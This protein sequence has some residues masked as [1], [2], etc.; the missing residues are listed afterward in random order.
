[1]IQ[2]LKTIFALAGWG[3]LE[4]FSEEDEILLLSVL[5]DSSYD[6]LDEGESSACSVE[7]KIFPKSTLGFRELGKK[8][9]LA[10]SIDGLFSTQSTTSELS[11]IFIPDKFL[12]PK[13][14]P[15][16]RPLLIL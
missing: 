5:T 8:W 13:P 11:N 3:F 4:T 12:S 9:S 10:N 15:L 2:G 14:F 1:M 16:N 7:V 6:L